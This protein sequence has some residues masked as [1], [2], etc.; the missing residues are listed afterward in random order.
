MSKVNEFL[1]KYQMDASNIN[2]D[3]A[4]NKFTLEINKGLARFNTIDECSIPMIPT[5]LNPN[6]DLKKGE[7]V[8]VVDAG[9]TNLRVGIAK[10]DGKDFEVTDCT[11]DKMP[12]VDREYSANEFFDY[13]AIRCIPYLDQAT[14]IGFC[15][16]Y[17][18]AMDA[19]LDGKLVAWAK[20][21]K[22][23][24][25]VGKYVGKSLLDA[26]KKYSP[27]ER[28]IVVLNDTT[29]VLLGGK[30]L[31]YDHEFKKYVGA[32]YGTGFNCCY[33]EDSKNI[34][35]FD[36]LSG[37]MIIN[38]E[39]GNF[40]GFTRG[41][42]DDELTNE[43]ALK[44]EALTEKMSSGRYLASLIYKA[45]LKAVEDGLL[46]KDT[47]LPDYKGFKLS[48]V[49]MYLAGLHN[50]LDECFASS[51]DIETFKEI[52]YALINRAS[53]I[54]ATTI[55]AF[56]IKSGVDKIGIILEG[57]TFY[58]LPT[59]KE[60]FNDYLKEILDKYHIYYRLIDGRGR[61][62]IGAAVAAMCKVS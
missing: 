24:E 44:N 36:N 61:N 22:A 41:L 37:D 10:Y 51:D 20:E 27:V 28:K 29:A 16:S 3:D 2:I 56:A 7:K 23:I 57:S 12:A 5:F 14:N 8:I 17:Q 47:K 13:I 45:T 6:I 9:G 39:T 38:T 55:G 31:D 19:S 26:I 18:V 32:I 1:K 15:F 53:K 33:I 46:S 30:M 25:V 4:L 11:E 49:S 62:L 21:I 40:N 60:S 54:V 48:F 52:S 58:K 35:K 43:S 34:K 50:D 42:F 59:F